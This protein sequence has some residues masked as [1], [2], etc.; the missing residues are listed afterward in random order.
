[1]ENLQSDKP[2]VKKSH[3][4]TM[5]CEHILKLDFRSKDGIKLK[6]TLGKSASEIKKQARLCLVHKVPF[7][8]LP[9]KHPVV[10]RVRTPAERG[11]EVIA[12]SP[13]SLTNI[14][15][16]CRN[17]RLSTVGS[18]RMLLQ[19]IAKFH[20]VIV[21][22]KDHVAGITQIQSLVRGYLYRCQISLQGPAALRRKLC[23]N[24][25][26]FY[27]CDPVKDI[28]Q[29]YFYSYLDSDQMV[30]GFDVRSLSQLLKYNQNN[31]YNRNPFST[32]TLHQIKSLLTRMKTLKIALSSEPQP[33][34]TEQQKLEQRAFRLFQKIDELDYITD[35]RWFLAL[36]LSKLKKFYRIMEDIWNYRAQLTPA[37]KY[38]IIPQSKRMPFIYPLGKIELVQNQRKLQYLILQDL[39][40]LVTLGVSKADRGLGA[41][42]ILTALVEISPDAAN[43][44][45]WLVQEVPQVPQVP[46][47]ANLHGL[48]N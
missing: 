36:S 16:L 46:H 28:P 32:K 10:N 41:L 23:V 15:K 7:S 19:R 4:D 39:E 43:S 11:G 12:P 33:R 9:T 40:K 27:S 31:P 5:D 47:G 6:N 29:T 38:R 13:R 3:S 22:Y 25:T 26:D 1:M 45:P 14:R 35:T 18:G 44:L 34:L 42:Y 48:D 17:Y 37:A 30:Y 8:M 24:D 2:P 21:R 20:Q